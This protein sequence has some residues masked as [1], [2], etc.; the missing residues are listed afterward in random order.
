MSIMQTINSQYC[1]VF[2]SYF[3][4]DAYKSSKLISYHGIKSKLNT[5]SILVKCKRIKQKLCLLFF[6]LQASVDGV[7]AE[8]CDTGFH[9]CGV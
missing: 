9:C 5:A 7:V 2:I 1:I 4:I 8:S 3:A 6:C